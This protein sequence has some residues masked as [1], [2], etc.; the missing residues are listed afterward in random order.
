MFTRKIQFPGNEHVTWFRVLQICIN[1]T[2]LSSF[3]YPISA[4]IY[5]GNGAQTTN[6]FFFYLKY[7]FNNNNGLNYFLQLQRESRTWTSCCSKS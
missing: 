6:L 3:F 2:I 7:C 5:H 4:L 1:F